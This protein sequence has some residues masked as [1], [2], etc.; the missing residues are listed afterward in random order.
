MEQLKVK[1]F[2]QEQIDQ[3]FVKAAIQ[4]DTTLVKYLCTSPDVPLKPNIHTQEDKAFEM[5]CLTSN[6]SMVK[7]LLS[8]PNFKEGAFI[9][10]DNNN[11]FKNVALNSMGGPLQSQYLDILN[12]FIFD[13]Q[14]EETETITKFIEPLSFVKNMF[15]ARKLNNSLETNQEIKKEIN[16]RHK[17]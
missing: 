7:F 1:N 3:E 6:V 5:A 13:Y 14:I 12:I 4:G 2:T 11:L 16:S 10:K 17:V 8:L 9:D 15:S